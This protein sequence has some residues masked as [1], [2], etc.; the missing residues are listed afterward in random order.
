MEQVL[1]TMKSESQDC[2]DVVGMLKALF[3]E[4]VQAFAC[5]NSELRFNKKH[6]IGK[7]MWA[8]LIDG[9]HVSA[10]VREQAEVRRIDRKTGPEGHPLWRVAFRH[11]VRSAEVL[12]KLFDGKR[13]GPTPLY[14]RLVEQGLVPRDPA[15]FMKPRAERRDAAGNTSSSGSARSKALK[16]IASQEL[17]LSPEGTEWVYIYTTAREL[18]NHAE[19]GIRPL[20]KVGSTKHHYT[21]RI[22]AQA[23][24]TAA[25]ST[26]VCL[27]AYRVVSSRTLE[28]IVHRALK[29]QDRHIKDA[30]GVEWFGAT[31]EEVHGLVLKLSSGAP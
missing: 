25:H 2:A 29:Q 26:L 15:E 7:A 8:W 30:P 28:S 11:T 1:F 21:D 31:P 12:D 5:A 27:Y 20:L 16:Y 10:D 14:A 6:H 4:H 18:S 22:A 17:D 23:G 3:K 24:S 9:G 13:V 19:H